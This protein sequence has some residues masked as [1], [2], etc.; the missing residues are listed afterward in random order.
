[1]SANG[2]AEKARV[3]N[4]NARG[5]EVTSTGADGWDRI[6]TCDRLSTKHAFQACALNRSAT[7]PELPNLTDSND[8]LHPSGARPHERWS[9]LPLF[10]GACRAAC[11]TTE[12]RTRRR[13][14]IM[15][16]GAGNRRQS[17]D[18]AQRAEAASDVTSRTDAEC[19]S[20]HSRSR[21]TGLARCAFAGTRGTAARDVRFGMVAPFPS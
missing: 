18:V 12:D 8:R 5:G 15:L 16:G 14:T 2:H 11:F 20:A 4:E 10:I 6:R 3:P 9:S 19:I 17:S 21:E 7:H 13:R 1:M